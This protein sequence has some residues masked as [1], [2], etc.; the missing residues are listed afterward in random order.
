MLTVVA[1]VILFA[2]AAWV[3]LAGRV[4]VP[5]DRVGIVSRRYGRTHP[6]SAFKHVTPTGTRGVDART[7]LP[8]G[9][10]WLTPVVHSVEF[11]PRVHVPTGMIG[12]VHAFEGRPRTDRRTLGHHVEC[13]H[14][15]DGQAFLLGGGEQGVQVTTLAGGQSY[16]VNTRLFRVEIRPRTFVPPGTIGLVHAKEGAVR[17][18][19]QR[20]GRHVEC[21]DFQ[22]GQAFLSG[23]GE[24]G[25]QLGILSG[26]AY[27]D[28][29]PELF[30][31]ITVDNVAASREGL[32][33]A[34]L[35]E[36]AIADGYT[37]VVVTLDGAEPHTD[38]TDAVAPAVWGHRGFRL[39]WVFLANGG[40]QG[41]QEE[42]L[43]GGAAYALNPWF[44]RVIPVPTR[45]LIL[46]WHDKPES[47]TY[48]ADLGRITVNVQGFDLAVT[49]S[50]TLRIPRG[51]APSLVSQFSGTS[52]SGL[53]G[54][55]DDPAPLRRFVTRVLGVSVTGY[56]AEVTSTHSVVEFLGS[57]QDIRRELAER[58]THALENWGVEALGT[59]LGS[60]TPKDPSLLGSLKEKFI[61]E[62]RDENLRL[63]P[64]DARLDDLIDV[65]RSRAEARRATLELTTEARLLGRDDTALIRMVRELSDFEVPDHIR[66]GDIADYVRA[67]PMTTVQDLLTRIRE[68]HRD[69]GIAPAPR[70]SLP[71]GISGSDPPGGVW[72]AAGGASSVTLHARDVWSSTSHCHVRLTLLD[73]F[74]TPETT[75]RLLLRVIPGPDHPWAAPQGDRPRLLLVA[76]PLTPATLEP[77]TALLHPSP[78]GAHGVE[79]T[80]TAHHPGVHVARFTVVLEHTGTVLQQVE[81]ELEILDSG[82]P[83]D[84]A[85][86]HA[87]P[88]RG[89]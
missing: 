84:L 89:R 27:Y 8:G 67:L 5:A 73:D 74:P 36:I 19:D 20:F 10:H 26:G 39:P 21:C 55:M 2:V 11:V 58:L 16:Y 13:D 15:Q 29:N 82:H 59:S 54:L 35:Q 18:P 44:V 48:D 49:L 31:V 70:R 79:F 81:T 1:L 50:Q 83:G 57:Y 64:R 52:T 14:F 9:V 30:E 40:Q 72:Q 87:P 60:F 63:G 12:V 33:D 43:S 71:P 65:Y 17:P 34:H 69:R 53:G 80:F 41:I 32:T 28:I 4:V 85:A 75:V 42:T 88:L 61:E 24:Q 3:G 51:V 66:T 46:M 86:P 37:G 56:F 23:G 38:A 68:L 22:D 25:R 76:V 78:Q 62:M 77:A 45:M 6:D 47:D 7:L